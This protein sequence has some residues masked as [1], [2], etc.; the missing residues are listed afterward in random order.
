MHLGLEA[1]SPRLLWGMP[2][3]DDCGWLTRCLVLLEGVTDEREEDDNGGI[4]IFGVLHKVT[5]LQ[6]VLLTLQRVRRKWDLLRCTVLACLPH[7]LQE[8][9]VAGESEVQGS[10]LNFSSNQTVT[11]GCHCSACACCF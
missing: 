5:F 3:N 7:G 8:H 11:K 9:R 6:V 10:A 2:S 1:L 4:W